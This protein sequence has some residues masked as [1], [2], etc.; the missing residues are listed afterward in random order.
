MIKRPEDLLKCMFFFLIK[1]TK[2]QFVSKASLPHRAFTLQKQMRHGYVPSRFNNLC[3]APTVIR[4]VTDALLSHNPTCAF[5]FRPKL[6][7]D[8]RLCNGKKRVKAC[9]DA[10]PGVWPVWWKRSA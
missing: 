7:A 9:Q 1:R 4:D 3:S 6:A 2:N 10:R 5:V 8:R